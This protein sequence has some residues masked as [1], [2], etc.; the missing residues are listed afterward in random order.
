MLNTALRELKTYYIDQHHD[1]DLAD[2]IS[3]HSGYGGVLLFQALLSKSSP[4]KKYEKAIEA[5]FLRIINQIEHPSHELSPTFCDG[6]AGVG[7]LLMYLNKIDI[8]DT[9]IDDFFGD[10][11]LYL[12][13]HLD[14]MLSD[15]NY[16]LLH[17]AMGIALYFLKRKKFDEVNKVIDYLYLNAVSGNGE[18]KWSRFE[19]VYEKDIYDLGLAHGIA[20]ILHF[21][22]KCALQNVNYDLCKEMISGGIAFYRNN[23]QDDDELG[24]YYSNYMFCEDYNERKDMHFS[25]LA[26][27]YGDLGILYTLYKI[28]KTFN[29]GESM[30]IFEAMLLKSAC[31]KEFEQTRVE[32]IGLCHGSSGVGVLYQSLF[33]ESGNRVF[34]EAGDFWLSKSLGQ[35]Y[36]SGGDKDQ[37]TQP[38]LNDHPKELLK[39]LAGTGIFLLSQSFCDPEISGDLFSWSECIFLC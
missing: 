14:K 5:T 22:S 31:R 34:K 25:R 11:D 6:L 37:L 15:H 13:D 17:G 8:L 30:G 32:D 7:W 1:I 27:C 10:V 29:D 19:K 26:W 39:G 38:G 16:D 24:S 9:E 12:S 23:I 18:F 35:M 21:L 33:M 20:G 36:S 3:L 4:G 2:D 28:A